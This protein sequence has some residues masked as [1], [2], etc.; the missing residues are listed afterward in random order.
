MRSRKEE[1]KGIWPRGPGRQWRAAGD[2]PVVTDVTETGL[3]GGK[4]GK[5]TPE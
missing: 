1:R 2:G 5:D 3:G 4:R